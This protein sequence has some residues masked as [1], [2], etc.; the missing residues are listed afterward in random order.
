MAVANLMP[1]MYSD[2]SEYHLNS[3]HLWPNTRLLQSRNQF[4]D[5]I[6]MVHQISNCHTQAV[7]NNL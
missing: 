7:M 1:S 2:V 5:G 3:T 4:I 6:T